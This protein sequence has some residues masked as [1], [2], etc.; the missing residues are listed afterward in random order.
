[1]TDVGPTFV[2][3]LAAEQL[4]VEVVA[5]RYSVDDFAVLSA[6][7]DEGEEITLVGP[8][9]HVHAGEALSVDG[10]WREHPRHGRQL[11]VVHV[12]VREPVSEAALIAV[13]QATKHVGHAGARFLLE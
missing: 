6:L 12:R 4:E 11:A 13:L 1:M 8:L 7:T 5:V 2:V 10:A 3:V 9:A